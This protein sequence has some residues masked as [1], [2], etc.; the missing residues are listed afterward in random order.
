MDSARETII[1]I[2]AAIITGETNCFN[3]STSKN[4]ELCYSS[5]KECLENRIH[6]SKRYKLCC[7]NL[8]QIKQ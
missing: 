3:T 8:S 2:V 7:V 6:K 5:A 4:T 1:H